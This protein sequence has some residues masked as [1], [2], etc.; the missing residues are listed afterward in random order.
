MRAHRDF[1]AAPDWPSLDALN[2]R[3]DARPH[4]RLGIALRFIAQSLGVPADG[5]HYE[6]R[7][8]RLG[9]IATRER[10]WHDLLNALAWIVDTPIKAALNL[11][12][13]RD[14]AVVG[15]RERT[16][17]QCALTLFDE[18]GAI[19]LL[20]DRSR[21]AAWDAHDWPAFFHDHAFEV[22]PFGHALHEHALVGDSWLVAKG[23][24]VLDERGTLT[25]DDAAAMV[26]TAIADGTLLDDPQS[27]RP[28]PLCGLPGWHPRRAEPDFFT[29]A[30]CFRPLREGRRYPPPFIPSYTTSSTT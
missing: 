4:P 12:Q 13:A 25:L 21:F 11:R 18:G 16:R 3:L 20:R 30:P 27:L 29:A 22:L 24:A 8:A 23:I 1:L 26:A 17:G 14:V 6:E 19:V 7:I 10:N 28:V 15:P 5:L 9:A 2:A